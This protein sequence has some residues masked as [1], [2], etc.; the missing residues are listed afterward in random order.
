LS[1]RLGDR[2][3]PPSWPQLSAAEAGFCGGRGRQASA[4][5]APAVER[6]V[7]CWT[8]HKGPT[9]QSSVLREDKTP[10]FGQAHS[11]TSPVIN[12]ATPTGWWLLVHPSLQQHQQ[13]SSSYGG[14][15]GRGLTICDRFLAEAGRDDRQ[16]NGCPG[17]Y[18]ARRGE[19]AVSFDKDKRGRTFVRRPGLATDLPSE[20]SSR[21]SRW[22]GRGRGSGLEL[23]RHGA[24]RRS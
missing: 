14:N 19:R 20:L 11:K 1:L 13:G 21:S 10:A 16:E 2:A 7:D 17:L 12:R 4:G 15:T 3:S 6:L 24:V 18:E 8:G 22:N 5:T 23:A 9:G